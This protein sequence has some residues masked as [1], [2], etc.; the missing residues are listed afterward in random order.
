M[1]GERMQDLLEQTMERPEEP[2]RELTIDEAAAIAVHLQKSGE[3]LA[4]SEVYKRILESAPNHPEATHYAGVLA[5][6]RHESDE[7]VALIEKSLRLVSDRADW[8]SN[9]GIVLQEQG[10][11]DRAIDAYHRAIALDAGHA[12]AHSNLGVL[13]RATG[14]PAEAEEAYRT[15][16]RL[17]PEH[18]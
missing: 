17:N 15:A 3:L 13:L 11:F 7:A 1:F 9:F 12:T 8:Y 5:H 16:I 4:A 10:H 18:I 6:Q 14:N 2:T